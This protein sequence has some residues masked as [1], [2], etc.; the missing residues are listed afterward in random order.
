MIRKWLH[1]RCVIAGAYLSGG[2]LDR[3]CRYRW[4]SSA[5][6]QYETTLKGRIHEVAAFCKQ[7]EKSNAVETPDGVEQPPRHRFGT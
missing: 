5:V 1:L 4:Q 7:H 2:L 6:F 3:C